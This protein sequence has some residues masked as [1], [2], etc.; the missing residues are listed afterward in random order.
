[1]KIT[2][3][4]AGRC[5]TGSKYLLEWK[6]FRLMVD[7]GLFQGP[8]EYRQL[9]WKKLPQPPHTI[10]AVVLTHAHIDHSGYLPR[11]CRQGFEGPVYCTPPTRALL[12]VLLL[13]RRNG[14]YGKSLPGRGVSQAS[15]VHARKPHI[16]LFR[17]IKHKTA[18]EDMCIP[19]AQ[20]YIQPGMSAF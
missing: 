19:P 1:M 13:L 6:D 15:S 3:L 9:N 17:N 7:C 14:D 8:A 5:V 10:D 4:G 20:V 18:Q 11:L 12:G 16:K 2:V